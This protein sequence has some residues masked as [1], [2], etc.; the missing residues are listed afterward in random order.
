MS[1]APPEAVR[2]TDRS[3]DDSAEATRTPSRTAAGLGVRA[4]PAPSVR[5][6]RTGS[7]AVDDVLMV[8]EALVRND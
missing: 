1:G 4:S 8:S 6:E 7:A 5:M 2:S 3:C